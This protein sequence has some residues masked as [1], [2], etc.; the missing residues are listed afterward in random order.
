MPLT[1]AKGDAG[2]QLFPEAVLK[3]FQNLTPPVSD[4]FVEP[5][6]AVDAHKERA[7]AQTG[8]LRMGDNIRVKQVLPDFEDLALGT[9]AFKSQI[10]QDL[11]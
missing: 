5:N 11:G 9:A 8:W 7:L 3:P 2:N 6:A 10:G 1:N 4:D